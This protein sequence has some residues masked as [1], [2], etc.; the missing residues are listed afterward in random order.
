MEMV[1][2][3]LGPPPT[4]TELEKLST[5]KTPLT[6]RWAT[7]LL[8]DLKAGKPFIRSY[9]YPLQAWRFGGQ[10]L[11]ITLG[12][13][14]VVDWALKFKQEF[15]PQTWVAGYCND[16]MNYIPTLRV[17]NEDKPPLAQPRW[18]YE[19]AHA[20]MVYGL[21]ASRWADDVEDLIS[22][23]ARRVVGRLQTAAN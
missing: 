11:L 23:G 20:T 6:R 5:D 10:Q 4:E 16:V 22:A 15:G 19:G 13:E 7:R 9:P 17:L 12:G 8:A 14:P 3:H 18:G 2:L 21:P 1:T